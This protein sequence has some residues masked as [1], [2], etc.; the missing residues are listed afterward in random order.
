M[1]ATDKALKVAFPLLY[2]TP[3]KMKTSL[4]PELDLDS[5]TKT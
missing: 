2:S 4:S 3:G 5:L 1:T